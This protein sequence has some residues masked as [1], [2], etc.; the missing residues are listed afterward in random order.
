MENTD[1]LYY[2]EGVEAIVSVI[3][4]R[5]AYQTF[6]TNGRVEASNHNAGMPV[7]VHARATC[8]CSCIRT[9]GRS[10]SWARAA[11]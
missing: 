9:R 1:V 4:S 2:A 10:S 7:P 11:G 3:A 8:P 6:I 5:G